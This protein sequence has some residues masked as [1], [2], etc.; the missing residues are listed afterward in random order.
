MIVSKGAF[1]VHKNHQIHTLKQGDGAPIRLNFTPQSE[2]DFCLNCTKENCS[3]DCGELR[4]FIYE[5]KKA[6]N[7]AINGKGEK[8]S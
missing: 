1:S 6:N 3:G 4:E 5:Q 2:I 8:K 7:R